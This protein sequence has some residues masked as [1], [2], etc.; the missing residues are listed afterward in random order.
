[1]QKKKDIK[2]NS[3]RGGTGLRRA[4]SSKKRK[5]Q[6]NHQR[7]SENL[8]EHTNLAFLLVAHHLPAVAL[9]ESV[10]TPS[11]SYA[12]CEARNGIGPEGGALYLDDLET[13]LAPLE[14]GYPGTAA[15]ARDSCGFGYTTAVPAA[16]EPPQE[17][18]ALE[19][20]PEASAQGCG[21]CEPT[22]KYTP[23]T[24]SEAGTRKGIPT[25][26][27]PAPVLKEEEEYNVGEEPYGAEFAGFLDG[28]VEEEEPG[29]RDG[30]DALKQN[31]DPHSRIRYIG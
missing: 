12:A 16:D 10:I 11:Y 17:T 14:A 13:G 1:M 23:D 25:F 3:T 28:A 20:P 24:T 9:S 18:S 21:A 7:P 27:G 30:G 29:V 5:G 8:Q 6:T 19:A 4:G 2:E 31:E 15:A 22:V 26:P